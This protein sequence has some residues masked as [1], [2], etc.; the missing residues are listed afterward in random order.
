MQHVVHARAVWFGKQNL[1]H[2][3]FILDTMAA[4][5]GWMPLKALLSFPKMK[6][7]CSEATAV[8]ALLGSGAARSRTLF[9]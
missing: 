7:W 9:R 2:D 6:G 3:R 5:D 4:H 8:G 1:P